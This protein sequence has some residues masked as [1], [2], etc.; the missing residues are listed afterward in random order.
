MREQPETFLT[1]AEMAKALGKSKTTIRRWEASGKLRPTVNEHGVHLFRVAD[2][3][4]LNGGAPVRAL[5]Q[6]RAYVPAPPGS[7]E[8]SQPRSSSASNAE[9]RRCTS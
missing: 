5:G 1:R 8:S 7:T 6:A 4:A 9:S 2:A 3:K